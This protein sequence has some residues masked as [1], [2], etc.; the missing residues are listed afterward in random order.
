MKREGMYTSSIL[1]RANSM[2]SAL[3]R[4]EKHGQLAQGM[5]GRT[6]PNIPG[7]G[8]TIAGGA[9][10]GLGGAGAGAAIGSAVAGS[11]T[12]ATGA[13]L[14]ATAGTSIAPVVGTAIGAGIGLAAYYLS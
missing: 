6:Q 5:L 8:K 14:G 1:E 7:P 11:G 2:P 10:G 12:A 4:A 9:L 3:E 13:A